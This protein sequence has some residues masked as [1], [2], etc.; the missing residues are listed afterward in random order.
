MENGTVSFIFDITIIPDKKIED[1]ELFRIYV[2]EPKP[3]AGMPNVS[4][5]VII[6]DDDGELFKS[7]NLHT[8]V[9]CA[10]F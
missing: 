9:P 2:V 4:I 1:N 8:Y 10:Y 5:D 6:M 7:I 3:P